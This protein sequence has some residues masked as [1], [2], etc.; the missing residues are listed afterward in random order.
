VLRQLSTGSI[1]YGRVTMAG[2]LALAVSVT[3][4]EI[5]GSK[6]I[7]EPSRE[8]LATV[9]VGGDPESLEYLRLELDAKGRGLLTIQYVP[10]ARAVAYEVIATS[11]DRYD[12]VLELKPVDDTRHLIEVAGKAIPGLLRLE[13]KGRDPNWS[14]RTMLQPYEDLLERISAVT[15]RARAFSPAGR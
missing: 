8:D 5:G 2:A 13:V 15:E 10:D 12:I 14:R 6:R 1:R 3:A 4:T 11:L 7:R 9:W